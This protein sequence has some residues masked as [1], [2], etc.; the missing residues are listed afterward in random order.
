MNILVFQNWNDKYVSHS[1]SVNE[2]G[3]LYGLRLLAALSVFMGPVLIAWDFSD[4]YVVLNKISELDSF[5]CG[6]H[7]LTLR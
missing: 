4:L 7:L 3:S 5:T 2:C 6:C 1:N